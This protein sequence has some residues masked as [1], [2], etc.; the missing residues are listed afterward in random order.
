MSTRRVVDLEQST[1]AGTSPTSVMLGA[2]GPGPFTASEF[3]EPFDAE[4]DT[5]D[6]LTA[7][8]TAIA[9]PSVAITGANRVGGS[10]APAGTYRYQYSAVG[11]YGETLAG[12]ESAQLT[13]GAAG[14]QAE[15]L[16]LTQI[17]GASYYR[18]WRTLTTGGAGT[19]TYAF[20]C[21]APSTV[22]VGSTFTVVDFGPESQS[23][24]SATNPIILPIVNTT[25]PIAALVNPTVAITGVAAAGGTLAAGT[26]LY[27]YTA[28][29]AYGETTAGTSESAG[30]VATLNQKITLTLSAIAGAVYYKIYRTASGVVGVAGGETY[31]FT[32]P[33]SQLAPV[34][35]GTYV[36]ALTLL[37]T[38]VPTSNT[39]A[40]APPAKGKL[41]VKLFQN[42]NV[43]QPTNVVGQNIGGAYYATALVAGQRLG[44]GMYGVTRQVVNPPSNLPSGA[45]GA[46]VLGGQIRVAEFGSVVAALCVGVNA[47]ATQGGANVAI[48]PGDPLTCDGAGN[49][50]PAPFPAEPGMVHAIAMGTLNVGQGPALIP[51]SVGGY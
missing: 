45:P 32:C 13:I 41:L 22:A 35:D 11:P 12:G 25:T 42:N 27:K 26:Y 7:K 14:T 8:F 4:V 36:Q 18:I 48:A 49:L 44:L 16:T 2:T 24:G 21:I 33:A 19:E 43:V 51:V 40:A 30:I 47:N 15:T 37:G 9:N 5:A 17:A 28:V 34:D 6:A 46:A 3:Q 1:G 38:V 23:F 31:L 20:S 29:N 39:T 50:V 10:L